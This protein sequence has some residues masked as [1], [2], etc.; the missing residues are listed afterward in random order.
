MNTKAKLIS[1][2]CLTTGDDTP[3]EYMTILSFRPAHFNLEKTLLGFLPVIDLLKAVRFDHMHLKLK[4]QRKLAGFIDIYNSVL[5][6]H[7]SESLRLS[8]LLQ[9]VQPMD[10]E[11]DSLFRQLQR[12]VGCPSF[13]ADLQL[14]LNNLSVSL[15]KY[16]NQAQFEHRKSSLVLSRFRESLIQL[17][18]QD[19]RN[20]LRNSI[21]K[22]GSLLNSSKMNKHSRLLENISS[23]KL[24]SSEKRE[25]TQSVAMPEN[26]E[27]LKG[28]F[29]QILSL[30]HQ[31]ELAP[32]SLH[33]P[34]QLLLDSGLPEFIL[35]CYERIILIFDSEFFEILS[36]LESLFYICPGP[37][38]LTQLKVL[39]RLTFQGQFLW[40]NFRLALDG[41]D[42][43]QLF[44]RDSE[45]GESF[46]HRLTKFCF[47]QIEHQFT[48]TVKR[49]TKNNLMERKILFIETHEHQF[50][51]I[52]QL[53]LVL[54][55][56]FSKEHSPVHKR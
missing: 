24:D 11:P 23:S 56:L 54:V 12:I 28:I 14:F 40:H 17:T 20:S 52:A 47:S 2:Y 31:S 1:D 4:F 37:V 49:N 36:K 18:T 44:A 35:D 29:F 7:F 38:S 34:I 33:R 27:K 22:K 25:T 8:S 51:N 45:D 32:V 46:A 15:F 13:Q 19:K 9:K 48:D 3:G 26:I 6:K 42:P 55:S 10:V 50:F 16:Q 43:P 21:K 30:L 53:L 41:I 5:S 39:G